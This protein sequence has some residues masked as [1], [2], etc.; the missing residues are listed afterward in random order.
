MSKNARKFQKHQL[1]KH[2]Q[3]CSAT[4]DKRRYRDNQEAKRD[5]RNFRARAFQELKTMGYTTYNQKRTYECSAC[6]GFHLTSQELGRVEFEV[7]IEPTIKDLIL[8]A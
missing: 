4:P 5:L 7:V 6:K 3:R 8:S 2:N 1:S